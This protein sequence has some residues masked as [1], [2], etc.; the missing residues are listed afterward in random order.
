MA[1]AVTSAIELG[2]ICPKANLPETTSP[3]V[4]IV[5][6]NTY[7]IIPPLTFLR[8]ST[9]I[10]IKFNAKGLIGRLS[11][12]ENTLINSNL[13]VCVE[14]LRKG[15]I[16]VMLYNTSA[17]AEA[18]IMPGDKVAE[19]TFSYSVSPLLYWREDLQKNGTTVSLG[20][21]KR[22]TKMWIA[23]KHNRCDKVAKWKATRGYNITKTEVITIE[24]QPEDK[25]GDNVTSEVW[26]P[27]TQK[28]TEVE[29]WDKDEEQTT[30]GIFKLNFS[31]RKFGDWKKN[32]YMTS[33][34]QSHQHQQ[35]K[36]NGSGKRWVPLQKRNNLATVTSGENDTA[37]SDYIGGQTKQYQI[38][39]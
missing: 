10:T 37:S 2:K 12:L 25:N 4:Y 31:N 24:P 6:L 32:P 35:S 33:N 15:L 27:P 3:G 17:S 18:S 30:F 21:G 5:R 28:Q 1:T 36:K 34:L 29:D 20:K 14:N 19:L 16:E 8:V 7:K 39:I 9:G 11:T 13:I 26:D 23:K 38:F 22:Q